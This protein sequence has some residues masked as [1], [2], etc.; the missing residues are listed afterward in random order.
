LNSTTVNTQSQRLSEA[1]LGHI[2][3]QGV[4]IPRY[5]RAG[6]VPGVVH[7]GLGA[8]HRAHQALVFDSLLAAGDMRWGLCSVGMRNAVL[9][10]D[11]KAQDGLYA[12][13]IASRAGSAWRVG[14]AIVQTCVAARDRG[15]VV[16]AIAR[17]QTRW[18]TLTVTEKAYDASLAI[19][20]VDGLALRH[21]NGLK[22]ITVASCDNLQNNGRT[23]Q[24]LCV[25]QAHTHSA[26]LADWVAQ[27]CAF[28]NSMVDRIVPA[29]TPERLHSAAQA[30]G[31]EDRCA[32]GTEG[33]WEWVIERKFVDVSDEAALV[34]QG[35]LVVDDVLPFE[36]AKLRMLNASHTAMACIGAVA[37]LQ[38]IEQCITQP[39]V[40]RYV[41]GLN[42]LEVSPH[43]RRPSW[44]AY[45]D[46]LVERWQNPALLH[47][48]HQIATDSSIKISQRFPPCIVGQLATKQSVEHL[49]F[50]AA[51]WMRYA[52]GVDESGASYAVND[53]LAE[54]VQALARAHAGD[55]AATVQALGG[56]A[57]IWGDALIKHEFWLS[58]VTH[59]LQTI[60]SHGILAATAM[61]A[62]RP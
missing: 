12:V 55:A 10:D 13:Q 54:R 52:R 51:A 62:D 8:F 36:E 16:Q 35:V 31:F 34:S 46:A 27:E 45:L 56:I 15:E 20:I 50:A 48:V 57:E 33:F 49:A 26:A 11:L 23:L 32:L 59:W 39:A 24:A 4:E 17:P 25:A 43:V 61:C 21:K 3:N 7:L 53:P 5:Q 42:R 14:G 30:L 40:L 6:L 47:S 44:Q 9:A 58:R 38:V 2:Q 29:A 28:P 19:L 41:T 1:A 18:L 60:Q 22:G 37:G